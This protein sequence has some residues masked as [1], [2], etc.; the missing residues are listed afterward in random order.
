MVEDFKGY[1]FVASILKTP[2]ATQLIL[3]ATFLAYFFKKEFIK[4]FLIV[5][6]FL[7]LPVVFLHCFFQFFL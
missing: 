4:R 2:I 6:E 5:E 7:I 1:Y 3:L